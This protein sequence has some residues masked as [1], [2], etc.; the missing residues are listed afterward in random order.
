MANIAHTACRPA[1]FE[2]PLSSRQFRIIG[3]NRRQQPARLGYGRSRLTPQPRRLPDFRAALTMLQSGRSRSLKARYRIRS[4]TLAAVIFA[5]A[6]PHRCRRART[7]FSISSATPRR[8]L[9]R[10]Q[11]N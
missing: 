10:S 11:S 9:G 4:G 8:S 5:S 7:A 2:E 1:E 6:I 3:F